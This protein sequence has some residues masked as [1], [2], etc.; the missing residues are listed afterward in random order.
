M[1]LQEDLSL[2]GD[3]EYRP[4]PYDP[5]LPLAIP[6]RSPDKWK[7]LLSSLPPPFCDIRSFELEG[8]GYSAKDAED[9]LICVLP[10]GAI[11]QLLSGR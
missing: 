5:P 3:Q 11:P 8:D 7:G 2:D 9:N 1:I 4:I 6:Y 10:P